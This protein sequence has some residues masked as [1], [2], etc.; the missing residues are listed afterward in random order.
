[1]CAETFKAKPTGNNSGYINYSKRRPRGIK[2]GNNGAI[3]DWNSA[4][5][6]VPL[7]GKKC[8]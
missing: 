2:I 8:Q 4:D 7:Q 3:R 6:T 1:M 5:G